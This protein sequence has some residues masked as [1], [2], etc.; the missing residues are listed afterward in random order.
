L[1]PIER[2][3]VSVVASY[4]VVKKKTTINYMKTIR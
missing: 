2:G 1:I 4:F 3:K